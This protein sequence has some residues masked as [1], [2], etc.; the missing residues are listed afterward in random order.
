MATLSEIAAGLASLHGWEA[1]GGEIA[2]EYALA[3]FK[4]AGRFI[5]RLSYEAEARDHHPDLEVH[6]NRVKVNLSTHSEG[7]VTEKDLDLAAAIEAAAG[8]P[9]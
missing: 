9:R 2:T 1:G 4:E 8:G 7:G 3:V 6:Y 5:V